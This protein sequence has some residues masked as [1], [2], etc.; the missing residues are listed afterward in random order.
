[1]TNYHS[2]Q[3]ISLYIDKIASSIK[4]NLG[5]EKF[6]P[7]FD[8]E[9][10][11]IGPKGER[12]PFEARVDYYGDLN[13][14][15]GLKQVYLRV[16][17][18]I[19]LDHRILDLLEF[20]LNNI[21]QENLFFL[22][23]LEGFFNHPLNL[24]YTALTLHAIDTV[25]LTDKHILDLGCA[26]GILTILAFKK[27]AR[28]VTAVEVNP[29]YQELLFSNLKF[30]GFELESLKFIKHDIRNI[31]QLLRIID[32]EDIEV[33]FL[34]IGSHPQTG[35]T[36][37]IAL[38]SLKEFPKL[39]VVIAG[40][41]CKTVPGHYPSKAFEIL[42]DQGFTSPIMEVTDPVIEKL[43]FITSKP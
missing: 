37:L 17:N 18:K 11:L 14:D 31:N 4:K 25:D 32:K 12:V 27:G 22:D 3:D 40:G 16:G 20:P 9:E 30:N 26:E 21:L 15:G 24:K 28:K 5:L 1:M 8:F 6:I 19:I 29:K 7:G 42:R 10:T 33:I 13:V 34:N 39:K 2:K 43:S 41:Y 23:R 36:D 38:S 35:N